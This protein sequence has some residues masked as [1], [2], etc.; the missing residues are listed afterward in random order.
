MSSS[1]GQR[2]AREEDRGRL[3]DVEVDAVTGEIAREYIYAG[4]ARR[5]DRKVFDRAKKL[6][7]NMPKPN[8]DHKLTAPLTIFQTAK[9][10]K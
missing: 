7:A 8:P 10:N 2:G 1:G 9:R 4:R 3:A 5:P 6:L